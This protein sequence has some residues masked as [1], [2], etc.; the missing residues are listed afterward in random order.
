MRW[1]EYRLLLFFV[2]YLDSS[3]VLETELVDFL[4]LFEG[5]VDF[6]DPVGV[7]ELLLDFLLDDADI[8]D[9]LETL[10]ECF[11]LHEFLDVEYLVGHHLVDEGDEELRGELLAEVAVVVDVVAFEDLED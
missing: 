1:E 3:K 7:R 6:G 5:V 2:E 8:E 9:A 10:G 11:V 4:L